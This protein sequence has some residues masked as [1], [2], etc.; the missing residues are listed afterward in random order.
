MRFPDNTYTMK[1]DKPSP[2]NGMRYQHLVDN[3]R[4]GVIICQPVKDGSD[5]LLLDLNKTAKE[6][7]RT[8]KEE[9][10]GKSVREVFPVISENGLFKLLAEVYRTGKPKR[11]PVTLYKDQRIAEWMEYFVLQLQGGEVV[12]IFN[13]LTEYKMTEEKLLKSEERLTLSLDIMGVGLW[14]WHIPSGKVFFSDVCFTMAGYKPGDFKASFETWR[15]LIHPDDQPEA[16]EHMDTVMRNPENLYEAEFRFRRKDSSYMWIQA[17]GRIVELDE[18]GDPLRMLGTH[19]DITPLK[20]EA[21]QACQKA[22]VAVERQ[23]TLLEISRLH[24]SD[25]QRTWQI[26]TEKSAET[27]LADRASIWSFSQDNSMLICKDLF[28]RS[29]SEHHERTELL[30]AHY[31]SYFKALETSRYIDS[32]DG[33][34]D[35]RTR[36]FTE[37]Y[38]NPHG[39]KSL[40]DVPVRKG[41]KLAGV[42]CFEYTD[43]I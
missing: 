2:A 25:Y 37:G 11:L 17:K 10:I 15:N 8:V 6:L 38:L 40:L 36:E 34:T 32:S 4:S 3:L 26:I 7:N 24:Q 21:E 27:L 42:V 20:E 18:K 13:D 39:I 43:Q 22:L 35:P 12:A 31:P 28:V 33:V 9:L 5:F 16:L 14:D 30:C 23:K 19:T 29:S 41:G 1:K